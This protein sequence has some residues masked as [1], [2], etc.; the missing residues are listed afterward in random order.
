LYAGIKRIPV[1]GQFALFKD[2]TSKISE[3]EP[4][5]Q[6]T[7]T[8]QT[9]YGEWIQLQLATASP[10]TSYQLAGRVGYH[11]SSRN[12]VA[13]C[14][15]GSN[16]GASWIVVDSRTDSGFGT[17]SLSSAS[18]SYSYYRIILT[19]VS[20]SPTIDIGGF[21]LYNGSS[22]FGHHANYTIGAGPSSY[23]NILL[24]NGQPVCTTTFSWNGSGTW[25]SF[26]I[27]ADGSAGAPPGSFVC[28]LL[29]TL[30][31]Y[32]KAAIGNPYFA[33]FNISFGY[34]YNS[35]YTAVSGTS[36]IVTVVTVVATTDIY[37]GIIADSFGC[38]SDM[39]LKKNIVNLDG[40]LDKLD[41]IRG[42]YHDWIDENQSKDRQIGVIAQE[43][44][45]IY[46]ELVTKGENGYLSVNYP[47]LTAVLI[48]AVK[49][50]KAIVCG[51]SHRHTASK[52]RKQ[53][54]SETRKHK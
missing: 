6:I 39:N 49:E 16:D 44:Q 40:A 38:A 13:W 41:N 25:N 54:S 23:Y 29:P 21:I 7:Q 12:P 31:G 18:A 43:V 17:Y 36:T 37:A 5:G 20:A 33:G 47:K 2:A 26:G 9:V 32:N 51:P 3:T 30:D 35:S 15:A 34:E 46:P 4:A 52:K 24:L 27:S 45:A 1:T 11:P 50:L 22:L 10:I 14:V 42:V 48:Q 28:A 19:Q 53:M 8:Q